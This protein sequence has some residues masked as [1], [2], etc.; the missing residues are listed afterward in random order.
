MDVLF[1]FPLHSYVYCNR[2]YI[3]PYNYGLRILATNE[4]LSSDRNIIGILYL[5][6]IDLP[7][8]DKDMYLWFI[9]LLVMHIIC[10]TL[11]L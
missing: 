9:A 6:I 11:L 10:I 5:A 2:Y 7:T 3:N 8:S 4:F 1:F